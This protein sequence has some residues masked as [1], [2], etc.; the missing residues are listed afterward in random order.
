M[1]KY[2][3]IVVAI[4]GAVVAFISNYLS[5]TNQLKF[6]QMKLK[7]TFY[8]KYVKSL[9]EN[10]NNLDDSN[11][12]IAENHA[13]NDL[14]LIASP[15]V[16]LSLYEFKNLTINHLKYGNV[17]NYENKFTQLLTSLIKEIRIDLHG[18]DK[19]INKGLNDIYMLSGFIKHGLS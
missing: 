19:K 18:N 8:L 13:F 9:S 16:L 15:K 12:T 17:E 11:F 4:I 10:M 3:A 6:E 5:K 1:E 2:V 14:I 7:Q